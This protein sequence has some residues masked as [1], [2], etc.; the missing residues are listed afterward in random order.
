MWPAHGVQHTA[1]RQNYKHGRHQ[2]TELQIWLLANM[3]AI[4]QWMFVMVASWFALNLCLCNSQ[5]D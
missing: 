5:S 2:Q 4:Q 3:A 1:C